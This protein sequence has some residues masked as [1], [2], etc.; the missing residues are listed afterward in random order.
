MNDTP[1]FSDKKFKDIAIKPT[2][3]AYI[4]VGIWGLIVVG[5]ILHKVKSVSYLDDNCAKYNLYNQCIEYK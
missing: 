1:Q 2:Y 5:V 4:I 3:I